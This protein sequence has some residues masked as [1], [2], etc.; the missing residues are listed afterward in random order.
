MLASSKGRIAFVCEL[1]SHGAN[2]NGED[3]DS[4]SALL[5]AAKEGY[6]DVCHEL[7]E[8]GAD[9]DHRDMVSFLCLTRL[10]FH[11]CF[12]GRMDRAYVGDI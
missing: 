3:D 10:S 4:W 2:P 5:C 11:F 12:L 6:T 8:H 1:L 7:L 9:I